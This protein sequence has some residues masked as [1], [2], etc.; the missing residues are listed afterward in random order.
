[1]GRHHV[2]VYRTLSDLCAIVGVYDTDPARAASMASSYGV[3][4]FEQID[5]LLEAVGAV[6]IASPSHLHVAHA[7][8]ALAAGVHVLVE[9]PVALSVADAEPLRLAAQAAPLLVLQV[10]HVE[11]FN[12]AIVVLRGILADASLIALDIRRLSPAGGRSPDT[13]VIQDLML[14]DIHVALTL[15]E[16]RVV[17]V[18]AAA[19]P[20]RTPQQAEYATSH[21]LFDDGV[22]A[23]LSASRVTEAKIRHLSATTTDSHVTMDYLRRTIEVSR[24]TRFD[25]AHGGPRSYRQE[26][27]IE[28]F[29]VPEEE[30]LVAQ[31]RSFLHLASEG[32]HPEVDL[33]MGLRC[34]EVVD[35]IRAAVTG[36][37]KADALA[38]DRA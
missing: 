23:S 16:S 21:L 10:G 20:W 34:I 36:A 3:H 4:A 8:R 24:W 37:V 26:S 13:D 31:L 1:M 12:P 18:Q 22:V 7:V 28:R 14:H 30:P 25:E 19:A 32:G 9:K 33:S 11:H 17:S 38:R 27:M 5:D 2:R 29:Y 6:S 15:D 35:R